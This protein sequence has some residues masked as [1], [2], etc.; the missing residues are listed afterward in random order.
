MTARHASADRGGTGRTPSRLAWYLRQNRWRRVARR[1]RWWLA[2]AAVTALL[3][4]ALWFLRTR[5]PESFPSSLRDLSAERLPPLRAYR[6]YFGNQSGRGLQSQ[7]R[8]LEHRLDLEE[9]I[10]E[11]TLALLEGARRGGVSPWPSQT[12]I[13]DLFLSASGVVYLNLG[14]SLRW[15]APRGDYVEW[16]LA[17]TLTRTICE[18]FPRVR[19][20][21][22]QLDGR[23]S[24][25]LIH[26]L[27]LDWMFTETM[28]SDGETG[29]RA[30][31][32]AQVG[33]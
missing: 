30:A 29:D 27:P 25:P 21:R 4:V 24:G 17:A 22:I 16:L 10:R 23:S 9:E 18:N 32:A 13:Q 33:E 2:V 26:S 31:G 11:V 20:V 19:G 1:R 14:G 3:I 8:Y 7:I 12:T 28:F 15:F 6:L 5:V